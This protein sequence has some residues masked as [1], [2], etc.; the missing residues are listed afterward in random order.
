MKD[1]TVIDTTACPDC[2]ARAGVID[3]WV[4][5]S[6][7]GPVEHAKLTCPNGHWF[8]M[9]LSG[10]ADRAGDAVR[11]L[12]I[13]LLCSSFNG[14]AQ[15]A[16][17]DLRAAGH[18][19]SVQL[20]DDAAAMI[21]AVSAADPDLVLCPFLRERV[22]E[23]IW[24][25]WPTVVIHPG[26]KGD[27]GPSAL[28]WAVMGAERRWGV[29]ALQA[30]H[31]MDAGPI[32]ASRTFPLDPVAVRKSDLY[33]GAVTDAAT[34]I[35]HEVVAKVG[36]RAFRP[37]PLDY[38]RPD[39]WGRL[40]PAAR[41][42]D[43]AFSWSDPSEHILR[44]VRA[45]DGSPG[46]HTELC[47]LPVTVYDAHEAVSS[48]QLP[49]PP[50]A[51]VGRHHGAVLVRTGD[52]GVWIGQLR[53][54][55]EGSPA[56]VKLPATTVLAAHLHGIPDAVADTAHH[57]ITYR[58]EG[59]IGTL[60]FSFYNGAASTEQCRRLR[61][62]IAHAAA[63]D[64]RVLLLRGGRP[65]CH[66]I[67][68][69][70]I[71]AAAD[72]A[73]EAWANIQA[74]DDVC[75]E[76][77]GC[78]SQFVICAVEGNAGAGGVM[79]ALGTDR[80]VL[81]AGVVLN[82]HY[83]TMGLYGSEYW[84]Y[85]LPRRIGAAAAGA[86]TTQCLPIG[87][88]DAVRTGL[89]DAAF[90]GERFDEAL[91]SYCAHLAGAADY[92]ARLARKRSARAADEHRRPL[93]AYREAELHEMSLDIHDDR[94]GFAAARRQFLAK[95]RSASGDPTVASGALTEFR[96]PVARLTDLALPGR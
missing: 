5:E 85:V 34:Q 57:E 81:R 20:A 29:T 92:Q 83:R 16:W 25:R 44:R 3:R 17:L 90:P 21:C 54:R 43:R 73:A 35:I 60:T 31:E 84:T 66:G 61:A 39:V 37:E 91:Q 14:L 48:R 38:R 95:R 63:Q 72:P 46:V 10:L 45:A 75:R 49:G 8:F 30:I 77:I 56:G 19:V 18:R 50:G 96:P 12:R 87:T 36:G 65:F 82:P 40:R 78:T 15:R 1:E 41:Q 59:T 7:D 58:R 27:R 2:G 32:W 70:V 51:V 33:N 80:V 47:G 4:L 86:L 26:P 22:P 89:A 93:S 74:I 28:D 24:T 6:T 23:Q 53:A 79:L 11:P 88:G 42:S 9:P 55:A 13:L 71:E 68:L 64:T 69:G 67:H 62:A 76:I 52:G 94:H